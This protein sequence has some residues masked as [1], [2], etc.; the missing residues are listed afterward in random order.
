MDQSK[1]FIWLPATAS[2]LT[3]HRKHFLPNIA[4]WELSL[5]EPC[6]L[7]AFTIAMQ[8]KKCMTEILLRN[9]GLLHAENVKL[10]LNKTSPKGCD[11]VQSG[12][13]LCSQE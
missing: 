3:L 7:D 10:N 1:E 12:M 11:V 13:V 2:Y 6:G 4:E 8:A 9:S 5:N